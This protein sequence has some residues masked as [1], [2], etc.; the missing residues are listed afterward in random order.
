MPG[1]SDCRFYEAVE[2]YLYI[3]VG[4]T[5]STQFFKIMACTIKMLFQVYNVNNGPAKGLSKYAREMSCHIFLLKLKR[6]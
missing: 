5:T 2:T 4:I 6:A 1:S 3:A